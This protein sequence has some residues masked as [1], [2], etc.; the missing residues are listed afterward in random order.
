MADLVSGVLTRISEIEE[1]LRARSVDPFAGLSDDEL[2]QHCWHPAYE[3]RTT[4]GQRKAWDD[5]DT[6]PEGDGWELNITSRDSDAF[7]RFDYHEE[8]YWRR[9]R[10]E[11]PRVWTPPAEVTDGLRLC[12]AHR[13]IVDEHASLHTHVEAGGGGRWCAD[14][15]VPADDCTRYDQDYCQRCGTRPCNTLR[16]LA[17]GLGVV[18][19]DRNGE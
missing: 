3:Y 4:E 9:L 14:C 12:R 16:I 2:H 18:E 6:P 11:G 19:E 7:E 10:P 15:G 13:Q 1:G 5:A 8:R 17:V